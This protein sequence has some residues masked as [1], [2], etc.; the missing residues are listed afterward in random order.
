MKSNDLLRILL[1]AGW[2]IY[3]RGKGSHAKLRHPDHPGK[4]IIFPDH[5]SKEFASGLANKILK[6]AGLK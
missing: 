6:Q 3:K 2:F 5:G 4:Q 1:E